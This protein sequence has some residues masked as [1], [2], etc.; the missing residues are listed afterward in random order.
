M[1][2]TAV[3][4]G[5]LLG[6]AA[7][8]AFAEELKAQPYTELDRFQLY[9]NCK[10][11]YTVVEGLPEIAKQLGLTRSDIQVTVE[12]RLRAARIYTIEPGTPNLYVAVRIVGVA[13]SINIELEKKFF[14]VSSNNFGIASTWSKGMTGVIG[15]G[16][17]GANYIVGLLGQLLDRF[18]VDYLRVN[19][20]AC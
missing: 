2:E 18:V 1:R 4:L 11:V 5:F 3:I 13:F 16:G 10:P 6:F 12:S 15:S 19:E 17:G 14:D 20:K 7:I 9:T 8:P